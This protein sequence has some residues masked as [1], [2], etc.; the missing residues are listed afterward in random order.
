MKL[1]ET[2]VVNGVRYRLSEIP[3]EYCED[4][5]PL[6]VWRVGEVEF[7]KSQFAVAG[8]DTVV[9]Q[10][11][12]RAQGPAARHE[13]RLELRVR[14][15]LVQFELATQ[16]SIIFSSK[17]YGGGDVVHLRLKGINLRKGATD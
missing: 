6:F 16:A 17:E 13:C 7:R 2:L 10:F 14:G 9:V 8:E 4:P 5:L 15:A 3:H 12:L 11:F 1:D